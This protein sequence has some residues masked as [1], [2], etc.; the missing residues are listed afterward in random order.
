[1]KVRQRVWAAAV[2]AAVGAGGLAGLVRR[3]AVRGRQERLAAAR[4]A[5]RLEERERIGR[6]VHDGLAQNLV[7][8]A[9]L[10]RAAER[11]PDGRTPTADQAQWL[12]VAYDT[13]MLG[14]EQAH[15]LTRGVAL[16]QLEQGGLV[17][18]VERYVTLT[19]R[20]LGA[21]ADLGFLP[22]PTGAPPQLRLRVH[23]PVRRLALTGES[24]VLRAVGEALSNAVRHSG[25]TRVAVE[26]RYLTDRLVAR[27]Q[28]D[29]QGLPPSGA[30]GRP[31]RSGLG[32]TGAAALVRRAGGGLWVRPAPDGGV[33]VTIELP[34]APGRR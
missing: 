9:M 32:L 5:G 16:A 2:L 24:A 11:A 28:D 29:G 18:A 7:S 27:V 14:V 20:A 26:L 19:E 30:A 10:L 34:F 8:V 6:E 33:R 12:A 17:A 22:T 13:V 31:A 3:G 4:E 15:D 23:G 21:L 25:A 1:V